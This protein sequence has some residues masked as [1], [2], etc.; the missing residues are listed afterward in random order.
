LWVPASLAIHSKAYWRAATQRRDTAAYLLESESYDKYLDAVYLA[1]Y[2]AECARVFTT[3]GCPGM[4]SLPERGM[5]DRSAIRRGFDFA[6]RSRTIPETSGRRLRVGAKGLMMAKQATIQPEAPRW[7]EKRTPETRR[8][9]N[10]LR[11]A[12]YERVD[13]YRYNSASIRVRVI[14]QRFEGMSMPDR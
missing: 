6:Q 3:T 11:G 14:D 8:V 2:A 4:P 9:E 12:G 1:G 7:E 13:A 10:L 5:A